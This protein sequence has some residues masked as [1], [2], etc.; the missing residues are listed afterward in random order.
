MKSR[1]W[2]SS[3]L[4]L[5]SW[6]HLH[7][8]VGVHYG[9]RTQYCLLQTS[10]AVESSLTRVSSYLGPISWMY[11]H[12]RVD[13]RSGTRTQYRSLQTPLRYPLIIL[14][15]KINTVMQVYQADG[16]QIGRNAR[17]TGFHC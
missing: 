3:Y 14:G 2:V 7:L 12:L 5:V 6:M 15:V 17:E 16:F 8:T 10:L 1:S 13:L 11:L 9:T 4:G